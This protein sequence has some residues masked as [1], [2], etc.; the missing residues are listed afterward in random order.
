MTIGIVIADK[1]TYQPETFKYYVILPEYQEGGM[2]SM[3]ASLPSNEITTECTREEAIFD[4]R[5]C[6]RKYGVDSIYAYNMSFDKSN[7]SE[8]EDFSWYD[9]MTI[10]ANKKYNKFIPDNME[11]Y[12]NGRLKR[13]YGVEAIIQMISGK[14]DYKEIH[15]ALFDA[16]DEL[17][18]MQYLKWSLE[19]Y[20]LDSTPVENKKC[21]SP[22]N[23]KENEFKVG[24]RL[25][26]K[27][28]GHGIVLNCSSD[29]FKT[30][31]GTGYSTLISFIGK[32]TKEILVPFQQLVVKEL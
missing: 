21:I 13:G 15:N 9:I 16:M 7:L 14:T 20:C 22:E 11:C 2:Y 19:S 28:F 17:K 30:F 27:K 24:D 4:L 26:H 25:F 32:G 1:T 12:K 3:F 18:I 31:E 8:L 5:E 29:T 10:A 23:V 6:L